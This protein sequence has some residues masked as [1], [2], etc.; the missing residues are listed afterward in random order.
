MYRLI[1]A[2]ILCVIVL[3]ADA[4]GQEQGTPKADGM[5][6]LGR[7]V[8]AWN[9]EVTDEPA[10]SLPDGAKRNVQ[11]SVNWALKDRFILGRELSQTDGLKS[12]WLMTYN[13]SAKSFPFW[14]FNNK[15]VL[16]GE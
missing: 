15:G 3:Q 8:G 9:T 1:V 2:V 6:V 4:K 13:A 12:L 16:G 7:F 11:Q 10:K 5:N 14:F